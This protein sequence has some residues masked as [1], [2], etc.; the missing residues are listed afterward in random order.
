MTSMRVLTVVNNL[1]PGGTQRVAQNFTLGYQRLGHDVAV[2]AYGKG[3]P[4]E[5]ALRG[6]GVPVIVGGGDE[7][8]R[9]AAT[10]E[11]ARWRPEVIHIHRPGIADSRTAD[12]L[13]HLKSAVDGRPVVLETN[14]FARPDYSADRQLIDVHLLLTQWCLWKW[15]RW[16]RGQQPVP[17]GVVI[18]NMI[19][20]GAF[21]PEQEGQG[22][23]FRDEFGIPREAFVFGRIGQPNLANWSPEIFRPFQKIASENPNAWLLLVGMPE[24]LRSQLERLPPEI[25]RRVVTVSFLH[26]DDR[27]RACYW[28]MDVMLHAATCGESFGLVLIEAILCGR[29]VITMSRPRRGN[30]QIEI[31]GHQ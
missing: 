9:H 30:S 5:D 25:K 26:G 4:R 7:S 28:A 8:S 22:M 31:V 16:T 17:I 27:L 19:E 23:A 29:P 10:D 12:L 3:G 15:R 1:G 14:I 11:A 21:Y 2:L 18:P 24:G 6:A 20:P 13:R